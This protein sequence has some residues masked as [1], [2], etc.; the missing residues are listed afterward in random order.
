MSRPIKL[1]VDYFPHDAHASNGR[2]ITILENHF[3]AAGYMAWFKLLENISSTENHV[4]DT[5]NPENWEFLAATINL[6]PDQLL[7]I[8]NKMA[9]LGAIDAEL[10]AVRVIWCQNLV[11]KLAP[12]YHRRNQE[13]PHRPEVSSYI[14]GVSSDNNPVSCVDNHTIERKKE[15]KKEPPVSPLAAPGSGW[16]QILQGFKRFEYQQGWT[17]DIETAFSGIDLEAAAKEFV[18]Y[19]SERRKTLKSV[20][21]AW[22]NRLTQLQSG[23]QSTFGRGGT[24]G[25]TQSGNTRG[26]RGGIQANQPSGAFDDVAG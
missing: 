12:L 13:P 10:W 18:D 1:S 8:V 11:D 25:P 21:A 16:L 4:I 19:W 14:N 20:K 17:E 2:T 7:S 26:I 23:R 15:R 24:N 9:D 3:G 5:R 22:R 6:P